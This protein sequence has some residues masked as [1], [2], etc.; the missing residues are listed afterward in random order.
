LTRGRYVRTPEIRE[1][2]RLSR[3]GKKLLPENRVAFSETRWNKGKHDVQDYSFLRGENHH[4][5]KNGVSSLNIL[6]RSS[7]KYAFWRQQVYIRDNFTCQ[8]C[9]GG[10]GDLHAHHKKHFKD[11]LNEA[12][13]YLPLLD[14]YDAA[15]SYTPLW[16]VSNGET[17]CYKCHIKR[18]HHAKSS[19]S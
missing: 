1:K 9:G 14:P 4:N 19:N 18:G 11:L 16:E 12:I 6:V 8:K 13:K 2:M 10:G 5:W 3:I 7:S 15:L 17:Q